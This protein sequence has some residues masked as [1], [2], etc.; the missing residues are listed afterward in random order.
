MATDPWNGRNGVLLANGDGR[1][2]Y[3][4]LAAARLE[5]TPAAKHGSN[6]HLKNRYATLSSIVEACEAALSRHGL[7]FSQPIVQTPNGPLLRTILVHLESGERIESDCPLLYDVDSK[8][9]PMQALGSAITYARRYGL[10]SL[11]GLMRDHDDGEGAIAQRSARPQ[12][13]SSN[14]SARPSGDRQD[15]SNRPSVER[16]ERSGS[17]TRPP[18]P[19]GVWLRAAAEQ[20]GLADAQLIDHLHESAVQEGHMV[21]VEPE[22]RGQALARRYNDRLKG[23][24]WRD[25]MRAEC[26]TYQ[27]QLQAGGTASPA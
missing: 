16:D 23:R 2:I 13:G 15:R 11:L 20:L 1:T 12:S 24:T 19:F 22:V 9:N 8:L 18:R 14:G 25:W 17:D 3:A 4:A 27:A 5:F 10:E 7:T 26:K 21:A 6:P